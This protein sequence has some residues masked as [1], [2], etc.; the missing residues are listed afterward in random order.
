MDFID[1]QRRFRNL[2]D[3][4]LGDTEEL[5]FLDEH[6][7]G[8]AFGWVDLLEHARVVLLAQAG[9]GKSREMEEQAKRLVEEGRFAFFLPLESL[10]REPMVDILSPIDETRFEAWKADYEAPAW[11]FLDAVDELKL[12]DGKLDRALRRLSKDIN[13]HL[14]RAR[15]IISCRPSDWRP[16]VDL[17]TLNDRLPV[18]SG[19]GETPPQSPDDAFIRVLKRDSGQTTGSTHG[20]AEATSSE[21]VRTVAMLPMND[22]QI[23]LFAEQSG[24][25]DANAFL[26]EVDRQN[27]RTFAGRPLDLA[28]LIATWRTLGHLGTRAEQHETNVTAKLKDDPDRADRDVLTDVK[29]RLGAERLAL[30]LALTRTRSIRS[31]EQALDIQRADGVLD[32]AEILPDWTEDERRTLLRR[33]LFDPATY[34]R[35]RFHHRSVQEYLAARHLW[36]LCEQGMS[37]KARLQLL[38][39]ERYGVEVVLPSM[40]AI[41]AWLALRDNAVRKELIRREPEVLVSLGDPETLGL[42]VRGDLLR[43]FVNRYGQG[44]WRGINIEI[45]QLRRLAHPDLAPVIRECWGDGPVNDDVR[46][47]LVRTIWLGPVQD[48]ADLAHSVA[49]DPAWSVYDRIAA[50]RAL[51]ACGRDGS[52]RRVADEMLVRPGSWPDKIVHE[53][54]TDLFPGTIAAKDL[55]TLM[56]RTPEPRHAGGGFGWQAQEI[57]EAVEVDSDL[58]IALRNKLADL[59]WRGREQKQEFH[60]IRGK[61]DHLAPALAMLCARQ[62]FETPNQYNADLVRSCVIASR[63]GGDDWSAREPVGKLKEYF[64]VNAA[65]RKDA[66]WAE[67]TFMD[68]VVP[69]E[70][71]WYRFHHV[72]RKGLI[73]SLSEADGLWLLEALAGEGRP[74]QRVVALHALIYRWHQRGPVR[75]ELETIR[76]N[77][78]GD[79]KLSRLLEERIARIKRSKKTIKMEPKKHRRWKRR[80]AYKEARFLEHWRKWRDR[81]VADPADAFLPEKREATID[82]LYA[83]LRKYKQGSSSFN[84][85]DKNALDQAFGRDVAESAEM[86]FRAFWRTT[87]PVLWAARPALTRN[88]IPRC[89]IHGLLGVS[90]EALTPG[91]T[92]FLS[93]EEART[94]AA[95]ATIELGGL[96]PFIVDLA[97]VHPEEVRAVIGGEVS[98]EISVGDEHSDLPVLRVATLADGSVKQLLIPGLLDELKSWPNSFTEESSPRWAQHLDQVLDILGETTS[99]TDG[100]MVAQECI[101]RYEADPVGPLALVWFKGL[102]R[103]DPLKGTQLLRETFAD[104]D[105]PGTRTRAVELLA[106]LFGGRNAIVLEIADPAQHAQVLGQLVRHAYAFVRPTDD[107]VHDGVFSPNTRDQAERVR[108]SLLSR[109]LDTPGIEARRVVLELASEDDFVN[110]RDRLGLLARQR[111]AADAEFAPFAPEAVVD[112]E[113]RYEAPPQDR[114]GLFAV[115]MDRLDDLAHDMDHHDFTDRPT[116]RG[117]TQEPEMQRTLALRIVAKANGAY[118][119][120]REEE[121]AD[122]KHTDIRLSAVRGDQKTVAEVKI[123]DN[124]TLNALEEALRDQLVGRYLR[125][126]IC[127]AGC[128]LLTYR[129]RKK[130]WVHPS[131]KKHLNFA[132]IV[133]HLND[134]AREL[135]TEGSA[136]VRVAA[137]GLD[138]TDP[139]SRR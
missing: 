2:T 139:D 31:P 131:T 44:S 59:I 42:A 79:E 108:D 121:V 103:F 126:S 50:I 110:R 12:T 133:T 111:T 22:A 99:E 101:K 53:V 100:K 107:Q 16:S 18:P 117:I 51:V 20:K 74:E 30:A 17:A 69:T 123:A 91:W 82:K 36:T 86:T 32:A 76:V 5:T 27:A 135:E 73:G 25:V 48:C 68:A 106:T 28:D 113:N 49:F 89:W 67:L 15:V 63:F 105:D 45:D 93:P 7:F 75:S 37:T 132:E 10:D 9:A 71:D 57:V 6:G 80:Q 127:K 114:D 109:L 4:E 46:D 77:L 24:V 70:D 97:K 60:H 61:F 87:T 112:L 58:A 125:H 43:A 56:E 29:A 54:A 38:F 136:D 55:I 88:G 138:L 116:V 39:A 14:D 64:K 52:V 66:F 62:L 118:V 35:V 83:W 47:L 119:V 1:L 84:I 137:F 13:S 98:A 85:W 129:G 3:A 21:A 65:R 122:R 11:F 128:L 95:Y 78:K 102:F 130:Y 72:M 124:W 104:R 90:A 41:A 19:H 134:K 96:A 26:Q 8:P 94:A 40:R 23:K 33:A 81:L 92:A 120:A 34:G 115:M